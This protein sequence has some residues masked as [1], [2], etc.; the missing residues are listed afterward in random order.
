MT[1]L[2][3]SMSDYANCVIKMRALKRLPMKLC[4]AHYKH[5]KKCPFSED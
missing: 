2:L 4:E 1:F 5:S 3:D